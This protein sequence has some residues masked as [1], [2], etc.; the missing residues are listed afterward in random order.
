MRCHVDVRVPCQYA[1]GFYHELIHDARG[2]LG[3]LVRAPGCQRLVAGLLGVGVVDGVTEL[4][5]AEYYHKAMLANRL[6]EN[7]HAG[8]PNLLKLPAHLDT[9]LCR[10]P[11]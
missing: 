10:P 4:F 6:D 3:V 11:T 5:A 8:H 1:R 2:L 7:F 9:A